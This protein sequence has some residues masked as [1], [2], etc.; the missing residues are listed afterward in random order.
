MTDLSRADNNIADEEV[1]HLFTDKEDDS[2]RQQNISQLRHLLEKN[3]Q[4]PNSGGMIAAS[5]S[6]FKPAHVKPEPQLRHC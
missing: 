4:S 1:G 5:N 3:L 2:N 6:A